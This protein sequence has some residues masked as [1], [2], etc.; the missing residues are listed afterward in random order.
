MNKSDSDY[1]KT[2]EFALDC[3]LIIASLHCF[4]YEDKIWN[5]LI[6]TYFNLHIYSRL[7]NTFLNVFFYLKPVHIFLKP[8]YLYRYLQTRHVVLKQTH[9]LFLKKRFVVLKSLV[10]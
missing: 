3:Y 2:F 10:H 7:I 5:K 4:K 9:K 8:A 6:R 1:S